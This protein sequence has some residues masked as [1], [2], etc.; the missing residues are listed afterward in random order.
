MRRREKSAV[1]IADILSQARRCGTRRLR[2]TGGEPLLRED[3]PEI[4]SGAKK[5][6]FQV[7]V[8]TNGTLLNRETA[9]LFAAQKPDNLTVSVYGASPESYEA[10]TGVSGSFAA[11]CA[12]LELLKK[13]RIPFTAMAPPLPELLASRKALTRLIKSCGGQ[14]TLNPAA[15]LIPR[16]KRDRDNR[17]LINALRCGQDI[18]LRASVRIRFRLFLERMFSLLGSDGER[19]AE[20]GG[21]WRSCSAGRASGLIDAYGVFFP[22]FDFRDDVLG[23]P[24]DSGNFMTLLEEHIPLVRERFFRFQRPAC[25]RGCRYGDECLICPAVFWLEGNLQEREFNYYCCC[26][27]LAGDLNFKKL[28]TRFPGIPHF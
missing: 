20:G 15:L 8:T 2:L 21:S 26:S 5:L 27:R 22:C 25:V 10:L 9:A 14:F 12:G 28:L 4:Y 17:S 18:V 7:D 19:V 6:G 24:L 16:I 23:F 1:F 13:W 11:F 3:F